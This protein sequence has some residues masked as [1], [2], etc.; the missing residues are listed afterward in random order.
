MMAENDITASELHLR[1]DRHS[2]FNESKCELPNLDKFY[3]EFVHIPCGWWVQD[4][5]R[6]RIVELIK[7]GW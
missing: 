3:K 4:E 1:N 6:E 7:K 2:V 5:D